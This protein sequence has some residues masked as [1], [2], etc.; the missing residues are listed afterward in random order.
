MN[1]FVTYV[2]ITLLATS[3]FTGAQNVQEEP[4]ADPV[5]DAIEAFTNRDK[6]PNEVLVVLEPPAPEKPAAAPQAPE[7]KPEPEPVRVTGSVPPQ[8]EVIPP[9]VIAAPS[10]DLEDPAPESQPKPPSELVVRVEKLQVGNGK[11]DPTQVILKTPYPAK[12]LSTTPAGWRL[13]TSENAP[14]FTREVEI[15]PGSKITLTISPHLMVPDADG[16]DVFSISEPG[17]DKALGYQ[18]NA[19]VGA[20]LSNSVRQLDEDSGKLGTAIERLQ[21]LL[22]SL[23]K[24]ELPAAP[25]PAPAPAPTPAPPRKK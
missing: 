11:I 6:K 14:P 24:P 7:S 19:T 3:L 20:I 1:P 9:P 25:A 16:A 15:S 2:A 8:A 17:Y 5:Q 23:P 10:A 22:V 13:D 18:Q 12:P 21:Q 4:R